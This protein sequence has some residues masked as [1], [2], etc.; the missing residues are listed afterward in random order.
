MTDSLTSENG[1]ETDLVKENQ[2]IKGKARYSIKD[3]LKQVCFLY[4]SLQKHVFP[5]LALYDYSWKI[6]ISPV[7]K[8]WHLHHSYQHGGF[9]F[10]WGFG[11]LRLKELLSS[12]K[13]EFSC[14]WLSLVYIIMLSTSAEKEYL[15]TEFLHISN[16]SGRGVSW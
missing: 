9:I 7:S 13:I 16:F 6:R 14:W 11:F 8:T 5:S 1:G 2:K 15:I 10:H 4:I 3:L 12:L